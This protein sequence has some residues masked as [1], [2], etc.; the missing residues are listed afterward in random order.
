MTVLAPGPCLT[1]EDLLSLPDGD[2]YELV[3]GS[4]VE[5]DMGGESSWIGGELF[6]RLR[7]FSVAGP[8]GWPLP[9]D[10]AYRCFPHDPHRVRRPDASFIR[11]GRLPGETLPRGYLSIAPD[12]A[13]EVISPNDLYSEVQRRID[14][15][16]QAGVTLLWVV[17]PDTRTVHVYRSDGSVARLRETDELDG[18]Q[19]LPGFRC[20]IASLFPPRPEPGPAPGE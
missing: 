15:Y 17:D 3:D 6:A 20:P 16:L 13:V 18:E 8:G 11:R 10:S 1:A 9:A 2:R 19:A 5:I 4:L 7:E 14:D 12:I